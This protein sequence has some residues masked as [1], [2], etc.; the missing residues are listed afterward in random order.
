MAG[1]CRIAT[2][3][4]KANTYYGTCAPP[5]RLF[6]FTGAYGSERPPNERPAGGAAGSARRPNGAVA[7]LVTAEQPSFRVWNDNG[8]E[9]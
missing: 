1:G 5:V 8:I 3:L 4:R 9:T 2:G 7:R 6:N